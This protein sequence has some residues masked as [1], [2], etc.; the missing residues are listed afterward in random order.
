MYFLREWCVFI[1]LLKR[2]DDVYLDKSVEGIFDAFFGR[3]W[4]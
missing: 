3:G 1:A 4:S 2:Y